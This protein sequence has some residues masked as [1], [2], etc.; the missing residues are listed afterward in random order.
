MIRPKADKLCPDQI[1]FGEPPTRV[2]SPF[3]CAHQILG[4]KL[5]PA[6]LSRTQPAPA[7]RPGASF[8]NQTR[9]ARIN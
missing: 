1:Q 3:L 7:H 6:R 9:S 4:H 2:L 8:D 5:K